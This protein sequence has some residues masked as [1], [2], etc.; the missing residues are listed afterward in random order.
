VFADADEMPMKKTFGAT[1]RLN[2]LIGGHVPP[3]DQ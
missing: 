2:I 1:N 3:L